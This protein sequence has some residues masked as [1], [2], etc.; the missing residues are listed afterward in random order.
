MF[1]SYV[2]RCC[3]SPAPRQQ[4]AAGHEQ[5]SAGGL[6]Q[7]DGPIAGDRAPSR[8]DTKPI[9]LRVAVR[10]QIP[11]ISGAMSNANYSIELD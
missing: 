9:N 11:V 2:V 5:P 3:P 7:V 10:N 6:G 1:R 4:G 8:L